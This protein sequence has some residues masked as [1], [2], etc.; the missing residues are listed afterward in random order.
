M[1]IRILL[2]IGMLTIGSLVLA[3]EGEN[4]AIPIQKQLD[5][6]NNKDI[7]GFLAPY[8]DSIKIYNHP[9]Q[10]IISGK[11]QMRASYEGMFKNSPDLYCTVTNRMV[12]GN[13]IM[14]QESVVI[15]KDRLPFEVIAMYKVVNGKIQE[16]YFIQPDSK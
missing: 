5:A 14:D 12:L 3:Q 15:S 9:G 10:L 7:E 8:S 13:I 4:V 2:T 16:V 1:K 11:A 6:Y